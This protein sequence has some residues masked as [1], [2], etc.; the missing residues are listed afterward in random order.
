[1]FTMSFPRKRESSDI[2]SK[3][4]NL[5]NPDNPLSLI[6]HYEKLI[7]TTPDKTQILTAEI[8]I[9]AAYMLLQDDAEHP[10]SFTGTISSLKPK[11]ILD[12]MRMINEKFL[13]PKTPA[14][15]TV[16]PA[17]FNLSQNYPNPFNAITKIAYAL[18]VK[19]NVTI[20]IFDLLGRLVNTLVNNEPKDPGY[21][22]ITF[23][24][25]NLA[26]GLYF[27]RIEAGKFI[28]TKKMLIIK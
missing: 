11:N 1:M 28:D 13:N 26:S 14:N 15:Q 6:M 17:E 7:G 9:I 5:Q 22:T 27:Y 2:D 4:L 25:T 18:P 16:I 10:A 12:G 8:N 19:S 23:D 24:A 21:Y 20:E 3:D